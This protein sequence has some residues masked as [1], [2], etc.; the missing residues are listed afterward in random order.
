[1]K[2]T[3]GISNSKLSHTNT[4]HNFRTLT[5][6]KK[7][8]YNLWA[9]ISND[10]R[11]HLPEASTLQGPVSGPLAT[12]GRGKQQVDQRT[13]NKNQTTTSQPAAEGPNKITHSRHLSRNN[14]PH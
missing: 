5:K 4:G 1:M 12:A 9:F 8:E 13:T 3:V 14:P 10:G 6:F 7:R 11:K 2:L